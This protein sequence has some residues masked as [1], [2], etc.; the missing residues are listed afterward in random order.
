MSELC[1]PRCRVTECVRAAFPGGSMTGAP[2]VSLPTVPLSH[3]PST[4]I[5]T[6]KILDVVEEGRRG[7]YSGTL[8]FFSLNATFELNIVIRTA[9]FQVGHVASNFS[10]PCC[11][12]V[13]W[14]LGL[15]VQLWHSLTRQRSIMKCD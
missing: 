3:L 7:V 6:M 2:K 11:R 8:G 14:R 4:Q 9:V 1:V 10:H 15:A 5:R 13:A 12:T